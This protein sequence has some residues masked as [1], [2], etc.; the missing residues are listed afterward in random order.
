MAKKTAIAVTYFERAIALFPQY[1]IT[2]AQYGLFLVSINDVDGGIENLKRSVEMDPKL[3]MGYVGLARAYEK[4][5]DLE[6]AREAAKKARELGFE[7]K[8][9]IGIE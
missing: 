4:K 1:A 3:A 7:G 9:P 8:L 6:H 2:R 5:G